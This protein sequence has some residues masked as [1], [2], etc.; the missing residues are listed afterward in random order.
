[1]WSE[2]RGLKDEVDCGTPPRDGAPV[3]NQWLDDGSLQAFGGPWWKNALLH[4]VQRVDRDLDRY[5]FVGAA[6]V[7]PFA[8]NVLLAARGRRWWLVALLGVSALYLGTAF[9]NDLFAGVVLG[10]MIPARTERLAADVLRELGVV[11]E[12]PERRPGE[13]DCRRASRARSATPHTRR[14]A[15]SSGTTRTRS[16]GSPRTRPAPSWW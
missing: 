4:R 12:P 3:R 7:Y 14:A 15:P 8:W 2:L 11:L 16:P 1:M 10:L 9:P 6:S 5:T 13:G